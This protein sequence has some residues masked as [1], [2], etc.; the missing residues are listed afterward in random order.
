MDG[1]FRK[2]E[3]NSKVPNLKVR[4]RNGSRRRRLLPFHFLEEHVFLRVRLT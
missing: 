4:A 2:I 3:A 1:K